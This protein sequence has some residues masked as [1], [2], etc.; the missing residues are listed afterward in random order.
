VSDADAFE[1]TIAGVRLPFPAMN[2]SGVWSSTAGELRE[3]ARSRSGAI[4]LKT[5]TVHPFLHPQYR[6]LHNPGY[7]GLVAL[8]RELAAEG[9]RPVIASVAGAAPDEYA[10]LARAFADAGAALIEA[11][12]ADPYVTSTLAPFEDVDALREVARR[13]GACPVP[14]SV[15]L[16]ERVPIGYRA[17][18]TELVQAGIRVVVARNDF[19]GFEKL[20]VETDR[21]L[22]VVVVGGIESGY[23]VSRALGKGARAVQVGSAL[24][25]EGPA[26]FARLERELRRAGGRPS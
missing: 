7:E 6:S 18:G 9:T 21:Q 5:A 14:V 11:N 2:A 16:P 8:V 26:L 10:T 4:V 20:L 22:E 15:K 24:L 25:R 17:L 19:A 12:L 13:L 23:D 1:T 3:L